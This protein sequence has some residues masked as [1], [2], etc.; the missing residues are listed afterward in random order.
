VALFENLDRASSLVLKLRTLTTAGLGGSELASALEDGDLRGAGRP[1]LL[2]GQGQGRRNPWSSR[3][4][5][6]GPAVRCCRSP[7]PAIEASLVLWWSTQCPS[8]PDEITTAAPPQ[9]NLHPDA[10]TIALLRLE[11]QVFS[12]RRTTAVRRGIRTVCALYCSTAS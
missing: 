12:K 9:V 1:P 4:G 8:G 2:L 7:T 10:L 3:H 5:H 11:G 6:G